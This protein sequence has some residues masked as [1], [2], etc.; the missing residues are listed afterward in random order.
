MQTK[1]LCAGRSCPSHK[2]LDPE[3]NECSQS[4]DDESE[5]VALVLPISGEFALCLVVVAKSTNLCFRQFEGT[6]VVNVTVIGCEVVD[7][8]DGL[9]HEVHQIFWVRTAKV[10]LSQ[11][12]SNALSKDEA[13]V[14]NCVLVT[15]DNTDLRG[16]HALFCVLDDEGFYF[17]SVG[18]G[19]S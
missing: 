8:S 9:S 5:L 11:N 6:L 15:K 17:L 7:D 18:V 12:G 1:V 16:A 13:S 2:V 10:V 14:W 19:P 3:T 4:L